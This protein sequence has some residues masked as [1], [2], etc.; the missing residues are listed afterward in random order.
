M[1]FPKGTIFIKHFCFLEKTINY[2]TCRIFNYSFYE[3]FKMN[4]KCIK[5]IKKYKINKVISLSNSSLMHVRCLLNK[6]VKKVCNE[7]FCWWYELLSL[8]SNWGKYSYLISKYISMNYIRRC[9]FDFL[10][11]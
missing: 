11:E 5:S 8:T 4:K 3:T 10:K 7:L 9:D 2:V 1:L 6:K